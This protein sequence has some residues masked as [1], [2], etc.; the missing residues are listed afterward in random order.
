M[1]KPHHVIAP[2]PTDHRRGPDHARI[3]LVEYG[4]LECPSCKQ[5]EG[6][7]HT[8]LRAHA[9]SLCLIFRHFPLEAVHPHALL[10][11]EAA[12]A[13]AAQGRFWEMHDLLL[14]HQS[15]LDA[16]HLRAYAEQL[17]L[18]IPAF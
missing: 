9:D 4:D 8:L 12:E 18:D 6:A 1:N 7:V 15:H 14:E 17:E 2:S 5:A 3:T 11:A 10:A 13:A 16:K